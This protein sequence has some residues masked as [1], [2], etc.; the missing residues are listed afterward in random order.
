MKRWGILLLGLVACSGVREVKTSSGES[1]FETK[2][3]GGP[4][5]CFADA[6]SK[7][8][9]GYEVLDSE[10][11]AGGA[12]AD[13]MPGPVTWYRITFRCDAFAQA[14]KPSFEHRGPAYQTPAPP[15]YQPYQAP[16]SRGSRCYSDADCSGLYCAKGNH[17][18][19]GVCAEK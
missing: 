7:C 13:A 1:V 4:A 6:K 18:V 2:C 14:S 15:S 10:S 5:D 17:A 16:S 9:E 8:S 19:D 11:H 3:K 12:L